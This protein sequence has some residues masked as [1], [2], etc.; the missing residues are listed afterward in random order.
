[1]Q[2]QQKELWKELCEQ[3][4][5]EQDPE[6]LMQLIEQINKLLTEKEKRLEDS[7]KS[8]TGCDGKQ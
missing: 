7:R 5:T 1:M 3:A 2:G 4:S 6:R 8:P